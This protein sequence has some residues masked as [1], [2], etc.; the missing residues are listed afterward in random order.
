MCGFDDFLLKMALD[1]GFV[2]KFFDKVRDYQ[3]KVIEIYYGALGNYIHFTT[4]GDDFGT[5]SGPFISPVMFEELIKLYYKQR[6]S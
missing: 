4:S 5:Q 6:I 2:F 3:K 1:P